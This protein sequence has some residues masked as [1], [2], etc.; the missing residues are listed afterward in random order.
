M[1]NKLFYFCIL[2]FSLISC[3]KD[4]ESKSEHLKESRIENVHILANRYL[5]LNRFSGVILVSRNNNIIYNES[6]GFADYESKKPFSDKSIFKIGRISELITENMVQEM[7]NKGDFQLSDSISNYIPEIKTDFTIN[8]LLSHNTHLPSI[9]QIQQQNPELK[10]ATIAYV[11]LGLKS[12]ETSES[13][14]LDYNILGLLIERISGTSF[15]KSIQNYAANLGLENTYFQKQDTSLAVGYLYNNYRGNGDELYKSPSADLDMTF[16]SNGIKSNAK[17][18]LKIINQNKELDIYGYLENDGFSYSLV[19]DPKTQETIIILSNRRHPVAKEISTA[20]SQILQGKEFKLPLLRKP[21]D[22]DKKLLKE[23]SGTYALNQ[24]MNFN[25]LNEN[26][27]LFVILGPN[28]VHLIPQSDN[29]FYMEQTDASMRFLRDSNNLVKEV[30]LLN[31]F[32]DGDKA[33]RL[34]K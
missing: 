23:Y 28:K 6:F 29:Q 19:N 1:K 9:Q 31:G 12:S 16:S 34:E 24:N 26:D 32:L 5:E 20:I 11:N 2:I 27:S 22:N 3:K 17:D 14:D 21:F 10:Y 30:V 4:K 13:S 33:Y 25:V 18:L 15:Q 7:A 8:D